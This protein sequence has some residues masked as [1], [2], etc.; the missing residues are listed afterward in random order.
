MK[1]LQMALPGLVISIGLALASF[2][3]Q[4][5][6]PAQGFAGTECGNPQNKCYAPVLNG[7]F[8]FPFVIDQPTI[9]IP[10]HLFVEDEI[11]IWA[12]LIDVMFYL[13][14]FWTARQL[15]GWQRKRNVRSTLVK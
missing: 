3:Y 9:S 10:G 12:F 8:P 14:V 6:G 2:F 11:R 7:G 13:I 1:W 5:I 4:R 15:I